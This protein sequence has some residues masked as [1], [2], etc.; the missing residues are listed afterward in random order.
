MLKLPESLRNE[1]AKPHGIL[2]KGRGLDTILKIKELKKREKV[3]CVGDLV[4]YYTLKA[5]Y[6]PDIVILDKKTIR[7]KLEEGIVKELD[8]LTKNYDELV[9]ENPQATITLDLV[10]TLDKAVKN[11]GK[12]K[13]KIVVVG[14][15]DLATMPLVYMMPLN[16]I[17]LYGQPR[18]G[19][20]VIRVSEDKKVLISNLIERMEKV[21]NWREVVRIMGGD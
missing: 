4:S 19:V 13:T 6:K 15:E 18:R 2:Y 11:L 16:S 7:G 10:K 17:V 1:F 14:E 9:V 12:K 21:N 8:E 5:G 20:V 3:A